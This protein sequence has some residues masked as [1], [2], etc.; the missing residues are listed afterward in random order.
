MKGRVM[1]ALGGLGAVTLFALW[2][3]FNR[4]LS[5]TQAQG[6]VAQA[7]VFTGQFDRIQHGLALLEAGNVERLLVSGVNP[8]AGLTPERFVTRFAPDAPSLRAAQEEG[9]LDLGIEAADTFGNARE[10]ACWYRREGL[11]GPLLLI[12]SRAHMPRASITLQAALPGVEVRRAPVDSQ[13]TAS[14]G[15]RAWRHEFPRYLATRILLLVNPRLWT[16][17]CPTP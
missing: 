9:R 2:I 13:A 6:P 7:V 10:T 17:D 8:G 3:D 14:G 15:R 4:R 1:L 16:T 5:P 11:S 12:T